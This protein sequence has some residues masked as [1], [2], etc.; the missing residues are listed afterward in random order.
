M[1]TE[2]SPGVGGVIF[3]VLV[4]HAPVL[5][6]GVGHR[7][8]ASIATTAASL[9][10]VG[11]RLVSLRPDGLVLISPHAPRKPGAFGLWH[12]SRLSGNLGSFGAP[13]VAL[14][15]PNDME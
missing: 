13:E 5:V 14:G 8:R 1:N 12:D 3:A 7:E 9:K 4:P 15:L 2:C 10:A 11:A 6:P